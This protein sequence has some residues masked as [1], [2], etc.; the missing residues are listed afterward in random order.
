MFRQHTRQMGVI[1][2]DIHSSE[3]RAEAGSCIY[4][5]LDPS[6]LQFL[7]GTRDTVGKGPFL[8]QK[9]PS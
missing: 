2:Q 8:G 5:I 6:G 4:D 1:R 9:F 3:I 7:K